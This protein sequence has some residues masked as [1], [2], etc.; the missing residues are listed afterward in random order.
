MT[1]AFWYMDTGD[2]LPCDHTKAES[3][4]TG[5]IARWTL[6]EQSKEVHLVG[7]LHSDICNVIPYLLPGVK[8]YIKITKSNWDLYLMNK[9]ADSNTKFQFLEAYLIFNPIRPNAPYIIIHNATLAKGV[10]ARY[11]I[12]GFDLKTFIYSAGPKSLS[13][14]KAVLG[15]LPKRLLFTMIKNKDF[16][17]S[18]DTNPYYF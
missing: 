11:N 9:K 16:M 6:V 14:D 13:I 2:L 17:G 4:N 1:N 15:Q 10:L 8:L 7:R 18:L 12:T 3:R 5:F